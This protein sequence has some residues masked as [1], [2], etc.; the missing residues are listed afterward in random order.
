MRPRHARSTAV[1]RGPLGAVGVLV[2][3]ALLAV[4]GAH[5]GPTVAA[6][7]GTTTTS[8]DV[9]ATALQTHHPLTLT[10]TVTGSGLPDPAPEVTG[11]VTFREEFG[12]IAAD[13]PPVTV[14]DDQAV[15]E[16]PSLA[17]GTHTFRATYGGDTNYDVSV[18]GDVVVVVTA[19]K[20]EYSGVGLSLAKFYPVVDHYRDTV[21]V[22][23]TRLEPLSVAIAVKNSSGRTVRTK[24]FSRAAGSYSWS[25]NGKS[26]AGNL[27][28][29]G[30]Y[31][32]WQTLKDGFGT[33]V[34]KTSI[35]LSHKKLHW[36]THIAT[37]TMSQ[38]SWLASAGNAAGWSFTVPSATVYGTLTAKMYGWGLDTVVAV[39][40]GACSASTWNYG[41]Y[42][43]DKYINSRTV[44]WRSVTIAGKTHV[45]S[46][47]RVRVLVATG[48][49]ASPQKVR[50]VLRFAVLR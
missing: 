6:A 40:N 44:A 46:T 25:W 1:I 13:F 20:V 8:L 29:A 45:S 49:R 16:I 34:V 11:T 42:D 30:T 41:C 39:R 50:I 3:G 36:S 4:S 19:D 38:R 48:N 9:S 14:A 5:P 17:I 27:Q 23:G 15:L 47:H 35:V 12:A 28:P 31:V 32:V 33:R 7:I 24:S 18:S 22:R 10:A 21:S 2:L 37:K 26:T 43:P